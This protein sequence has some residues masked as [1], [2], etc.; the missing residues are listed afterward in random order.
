MKM[1]PS[2]QILAK[3]AFFIK[4]DTKR[5]SLAGTVAGATSGLLFSYGAVIVYRWVDNTLMSY[6]YFDLLE[7]TAVV[8]GTLVFAL[9]GNRVSKKKLR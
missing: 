4:H 7:T 5:F 8:L 9:I 2:K 1:P 3:G 6:L